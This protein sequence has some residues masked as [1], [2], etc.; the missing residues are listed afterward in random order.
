VINPLT[1]LFRVPNKEIANDSLREIRRRIVDECIRVAKEEGVV[2]DPSLQEE[3]NTAT[4]SYSNKSSMCQDIIKG[5]K[6][7]ID[8]LNG[9]IS[10]LG[11]RHG[12]PTPVNDVLTALIRFMEGNE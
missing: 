8:F 3:V 4:I 6:T 1:A 5:R 2:L 11:Q 7:E 12:V 10:E 9:K